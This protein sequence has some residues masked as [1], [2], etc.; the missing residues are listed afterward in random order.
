M[1]SV[2]V[3]SFSN[4]KRNPNTPIEEERRRRG[5]KRV[6]RG[7][8]KKERKKESVQWCMVRLWGSVWIRKIIKKG[9]KILF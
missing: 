4:N 3:F 8:K 2:S 7:R 6:E 9:E 5:K 1:F